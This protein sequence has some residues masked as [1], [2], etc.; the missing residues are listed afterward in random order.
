MDKYH[1][2]ELIGEGSFGRVY[3]ARKKHSGLVV[4]MKFIPKLGR[5][6]KEL[7]SLRQEIDIMR[8]LHH[9]NIIQMLDSFET[10]D[11][12]VAVT[13]YAEGELF[14]VLEDDERLP[15]MQVQSIAC[16]LVSALF[17]LHSHRILHRDMK[18]QNI[19]LAKRGLVKLCDFGFARCMSLN[20]I[21]LTSIKGTPLYMAPE[22]VEEKPYDHTA[23]LWSLGCILYELYFGKPPFFTNS[24]FKLVNLITKDVVRWSPDMNPIFRDLLQGLLTKNPTHRLGWPE[25]LRHPFVAA[26]VIIVQ[27]EDIPTTAPAA[28]QEAKK[29]TKAKS[30]WVTK[31]SN[32]RERSPQQVTSSVES[33]RSRISQDYSMEFPLVEVECRQVVNRDTPALTD[34]L[35]DREETDGDEAWETLTESLRDEESFLVAIRLLKNEAFASQVRTRFSSA[36]GLVMQ[37]MLEGASR[38]RLVLRVVSQILAAKIDTD[39]LLEFLKTSDFVNSSAKLLQQITKSSKVKQEPWCLQ[40]LIDLMVTVAAAFHIYSESNSDSELF[41]SASNTLVA[42][43]TKLL[44]Y[45]QD[46]DLRLRQQTLLCFAE[47]CNVMKEERS[48]VPALFFHNLALEKNMLMSGVLSCLMDERYTLNGEVKLV[49]SLSV[50]RSCLCALTAAVFTSTGDMHLLLAKQKVA[51]CVAKK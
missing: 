40:L 44:N 51:E 16:Q 50:R 39:L 35:F 9:P 33:H 38:F 19:L 2:L 36:A 46:S 42:C 29:S 24:I 32:T 13:D 31:N 7:R 20:T 10:P 41:A 5:T 45:H 43:F 4:A 25:L 11:E 3:K 34:A 6:E 48:Q 23:D 14:Q 1:V 26:G 28:E 17:Y 47:L 12:V 18:P 8:S 49:P 37:A 30:K 21:V 15:E 27:D 22:L